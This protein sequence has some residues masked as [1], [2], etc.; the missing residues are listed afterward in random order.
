MLRANIKL[1]EE[2]NLGEIGKQKAL[3]LV[4]VCKIFTLSCAVGS[5]TKRILSSLPG[6][7]IAGSMIS[8]AEGRKKYVLDISKS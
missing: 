5:P 2:S 3:T 1:H 8:G 4:I 6:R 7:S